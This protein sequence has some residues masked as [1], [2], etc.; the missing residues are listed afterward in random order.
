MIPLL[1][2]YK[3]TEFHLAFQPRKRRRR[4]FCRSRGLAIAAMMV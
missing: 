1:M 4:P 2:E 3:Y